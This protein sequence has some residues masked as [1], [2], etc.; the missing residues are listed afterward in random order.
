MGDLSAPVLPTNQSWASGGQEWNV[1]A[2]HAD[3]AQPLRQRFV[4]PCPAVHNP[5]ACPAAAPAPSIAPEIAATQRIAPV[6]RNAP[7][8]ATAAAVCSMSASGRS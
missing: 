4:K 8:T 6:S 7:G 2:L 5:S 1:D 3:G